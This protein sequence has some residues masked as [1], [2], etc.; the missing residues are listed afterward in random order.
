[1]PYLKQFTGDWATYEIIKQALANRRK[2]AQRLSG[3][4]D[5]LADDQ[6]E[7]TGA[8]GSGQEEP[9]VETDAEITEN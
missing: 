7:G 9:A 5:T 6:D 2:Y 3:G 8:E 1:M 4:S